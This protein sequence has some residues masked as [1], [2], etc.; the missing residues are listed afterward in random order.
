MS[1]FIVI[2]VF[3]LGLIVGS[4]LNVVIYRMPRGLSVVKPRSYCT[5]C[6]HKIRWYENIPVLS[7]IFLRGKCSSCGEKISV[8]YPLIEILTGLA[9]V[10]AYLKWGLTVD[11]IFNFLFLSLLIAITFIDIDFKII[12]DELNLVGFFLGIVYSF[13]RHDFSVFDAFLGAVVG[14][15]FLFLIGYLYFKFKGIEGLG[16]G[17]VKLMAFIGTYLGWFGSLFTIF[18]GSLLGAIVGITV[19]Y[20][21]GEKNKN[22][23]EIPFGPFLATGAAIYLFFGERI[24][25]WYFG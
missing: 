2:S 10:A 12:P 3:L 15:G 1:T 25:E 6:G 9:A 16:F 11:F 14:A 4:F 8:R 18:F 7:Y 24:R 20:I 19:A 23:Y 13:F 5:K 22:R 17:D 21:K